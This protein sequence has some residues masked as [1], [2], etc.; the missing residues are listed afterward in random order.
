MS[1]KFAINKFLDVGLNFMERG[2]VPLESE[3]KGEFRYLTDGADSDSHRATLSLIFG[4]RAFQIIR[5]DQVT[6]EIV[7]AFLFTVNQIRELLKKHKPTM[8]PERAAI[9]EVRSTTKIIELLKEHH[10]EVVHERYL[11]KPEN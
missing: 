10:P 4:E 9:Q 8:R 11:G 7:E 2:L 1:E 6:P 3:K 5:L